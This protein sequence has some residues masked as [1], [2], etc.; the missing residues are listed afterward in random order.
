[1]KLLIFV[2]EAP[3]ATTPPPAVTALLDAATE[4]Y[5]VAPSIVGPIDWLTGHIDDARSEADDRLSAL[6][7]RPETPDNATGTVAGLWAMNSPEHH[8][9]RA[10]VL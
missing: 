7:G 1:M 5:V 4:V 6:W 10:P 9:G 8:R 3:T 2:G